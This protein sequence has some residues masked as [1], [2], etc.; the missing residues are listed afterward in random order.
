MPR[1]E[2]R[3]RLRDIGDAWELLDAAPLNAI[4]SIQPDRVVL[5]SQGPIF[6]ASGLVAVF[7]KERLESRVRL[8]GA[9]AR[10]QTKDMRGDLPR[11]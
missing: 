11:L 8:Q 7:G 3:Q 1:K 6:L 4:A 9:P 5:A 2:S 10:I